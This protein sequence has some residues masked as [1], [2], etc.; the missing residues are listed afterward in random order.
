MSFPPTTING[1]CSTVNFEEV[2]TS[3][4]PTSSMSYIAGTSFPI[5]FGAS[6]STS[7]SN[8]PTESSRLFISR[9]RRVQ[10]LIIAPQV[11]SACPTNNFFYTTQ[12][13]HQN[14]PAAQKESS[15]SG[16][17]LGGNMGPQYYMNQE[18]QNKNN[19]QG[20]NCVNQFQ[21][22]IPSHF[23][24]QEL[25]QKPGSLKQTK[26]REK[27]I[28]RKHILQFNQAAPRPD[29]VELCHLTNSEWKGD[30]QDLEKK[31]KGLLYQIEEWNKELNNVERD[32][33]LTI[34]EKELVLEACKKANND[35]FIEANKYYKMAPRR[36]DHFMEMKKAMEKAEMERDSME[37]EVRHK[38]YAA[39]YEIKRLTEEIF[40]KDQKY[41]TDLGKRDDTSRK[42][43]SD[44]E[45]LKNILE[46]QQEH[47]GN[48]QMLFDNTSSEQTTLHA[49]ASSKQQEIN[50]EGNK[51]RLKIAETDSLTRKVNAAQEE[52]KNLEKVQNGLK[53]ELEILEREMK[54]A[55]EEEEK[56]RMEKVMMMEAKDAE[57]TEEQLKA[58]WFEAE[59]KAT[60]LK[61]NIIEENEEEFQRK[62][63]QDSEVEV[64]PFMIYK[65][66]SN[67][68]GNV[69]EELEMPKLYPI[70][71][72]R[73]V[74]AE[75]KET[76][77]QIVEPYL[78][79][80]LEVEISELDTA[81]DKQF[82]MD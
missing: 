2:Y 54:V 23:A 46:R 81:T 36:W 14:E 71:K 4:N 51:L 58:K 72:K 56:L 24:Y 30:I 39:N 32:K 16:W 69:D 33:D 38:L 15:H 37:D 63:E 7:S 22:G 79:K 13:Y 28:P 29:E 59:M 75:L 45:N 25:S 35:V 80:F 10:N 57:I 65:Q 43:S 20:V 9:G 49:Y 41:T 8:Q 78:V 11:A 64:E 73:R 21:S 48:V 12:N 19:P 55:K 27:G 47:L 60:K 34:A 66:S 26:K 68:E 82:Q 62:E 77:V 6:T 67:E 44:V 52:N 76:R 18:Q 1:R 31:N 50:K 42:M 3:T 70:G 53:Q 17:N 40:I 5:N 61:Q 74:A